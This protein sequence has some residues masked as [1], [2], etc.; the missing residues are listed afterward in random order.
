MNGLIMFAT[1]TM[2]LYSKAH[3]CSRTYVQNIEAL[4]QQQYNSAIKCLN[5]NCD[6]AVCDFTNAAELTTSQLK[7]MI[8]NEAFKFDPDVSVNDRSV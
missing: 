4:Q 7:Y 6:E 3:G 1:I 8:N 2:A 5:T